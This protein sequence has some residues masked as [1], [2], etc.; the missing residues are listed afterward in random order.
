[1]HQRSSEMTPVL[2]PPVICM[3][4]VTHAT[5]AGTYQGYVLEF[6]VSPS[7]FVRGKVRISDEETKQQSTFQA[8]VE[9]NLPDTCKVL[10]WSQERPIFCIHLGEHAVYVEPTCADVW[11]NIIMRHNQPQSREQAETTMISPLQLRH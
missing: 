4:Y 9:M 3:E 10:W 2:P 11:E 7:I 6:D 8:G 1:M 5:L